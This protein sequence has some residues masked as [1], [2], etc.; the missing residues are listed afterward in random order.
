MGES[1]G[2]ACGLGIATLA[3]LFCVR[4]WKKRNKP[5]AENLKST[6]YR[7]LDLLAKL[8]NL[9][10]IIFG[11]M[12]AYFITEGGTFIDIVGD[13]PSDLKAPGFDGVGFTE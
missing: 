1:N 13:V 6:R 10:C 12:I 8:S 9:L 11:S 4:E 5:T 2:K 3:V 7:V